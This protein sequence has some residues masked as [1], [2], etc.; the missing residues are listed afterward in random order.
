MIDGGPFFSRV[1][2]VGG[3]QAGLEDV[4]SISFNLHQV[5]AMLVE[6]SLSQRSLG[7]D[8]IAG[9]QPQQREIP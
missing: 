4:A 7:V 6:Q 9:D 1:S 5:I 8:R 3:A 2:A